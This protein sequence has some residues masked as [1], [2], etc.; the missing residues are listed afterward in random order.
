MFTTGSLT[1]LQTNLFMAPAAVHQPAASRP[2]HTTFLLIRASAQDERDRESARGGGEGGGEG[3]ITGGAGAGGG[4]GGAGGEVKKPKK[5][6][7]RAV[8]H[9]L[10]VGQQQPVEPDGKVTAVPRPGTQQHK[11][12]FDRR[13]QVSSG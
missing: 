10:L 8:P 4:A 1:A 6:T 7:L 13:I 12:L 9:V 5:F 2:G 3:A 11:E